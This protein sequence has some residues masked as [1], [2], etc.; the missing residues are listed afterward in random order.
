MT[1]RSM[2]SF[3][4]FQIL[5]IFLSSLLV[6]AAPTEQREW[7]AKGGHTLEAMALK[8]TGGKV[9]LERANGSK[10][11]VP[12]EKFTEADQEFLREP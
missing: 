2:N 5:A 1:S 11:V 4:L 6:S 7:H 9:Q 10:I 12:M 8:V 3:V